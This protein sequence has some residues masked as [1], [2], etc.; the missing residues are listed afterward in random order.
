MHEAAVA[1]GS[2]QEGKREIAAQNTH[3]QTAIWDRDRMAGPEGD[4]V[5]KAAIF[6]ESD[7]A[8]GAAVEIVEHRFGHPAAS[9]SAKIVDADNP[10]RGNGA[11]GSRHL[12]FQQDVLKADAWYH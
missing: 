11:G 7:F 10:G 1:N 9:H 3:A 2:E 8:F 12:Q 6:T 4:V 5:V